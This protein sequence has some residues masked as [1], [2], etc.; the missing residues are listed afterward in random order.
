[1]SWIQKYRFEI[2]IFLAISLVYF[3]VRLPNLTLQPIFADEAIYIRWAQ[4]MRAE[5]TLRFVS[6]TDGKTPL[7]MWILIPFFK[8]FSDPLLAGRFLSVLSG[9]FTML[10]VFF[11]SRRIFG[12]K[13]VFW[14]TLIYAVVPYT[15]FFDRMALVD[16][17]LAS[18]SIW[19]LYFSLWLI[20]SQRLDLAMVLGYLLGGAWLTKT[21][22]MLNFISLPITILA[23][24]LKPA[25]KSSLFKLLFFWGIAILIALVV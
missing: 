17:M 3:L 12:L 21:P 25:K 20:K 8:I 6:V 19:A 7:F 18:F 15:V 14:S 23:F 16:S 5:P 2:L 1:M 11:L 24:N 13:V 22:A 10:G 9:F 4:I